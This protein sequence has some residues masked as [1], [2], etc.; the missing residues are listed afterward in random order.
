MKQIIVPVDFSEE[1]TNG[2]D[3]ALLLSS[4]TGSDI[5][6]V[7]VQKKIPEHFSGSENEQ[8]KIANKYF[9][10][11]RDKY[12][13]KLTTGVN[14]DFIIKTGKVYKEVVN[15]AEAFEDSAIV[16]S[17]HGASGFEQLFIGS[18][19]FRIITATKKPVFT[20]RY[21]VL[22]ADIRRIILPIDITEQSRQKVPLTMELAKLF[23]SEIHILTVSSTKS[24]DI[25]QK[26]KAYSN[27]VAEYMNEQNI[28]FVQASRTGPNITDTAIEYCVENKGDLMSIMT[29]QGT[30]ITNIF[31]GSYAHQ[32][33]NKAP[34][35]V[36]AIT[37]K[38]LRLPGGFS[39]SGG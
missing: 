22:P 36:M 32:M 39:T 7:Y 17:T 5:Q 27:Q 31:L 30:S 3:L 26:L 16:V 18:N 14:F 28:P 37:P 23:N 38:E 10:Q 6:L 19:A 33:L 34:V 12:E 1:S 9:D 8:K 11:L 24:N 25:A 29:E 20:I 15:Q 21:G 13:K 2:I 35:P 4:R